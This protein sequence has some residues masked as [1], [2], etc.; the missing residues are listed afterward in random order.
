M[1]HTHMKAIIGTSTTIDGYL[2]Y[3]PFDS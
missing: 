1:I 2:N 3:F